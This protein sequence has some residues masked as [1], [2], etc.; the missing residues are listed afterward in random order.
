[1]GYFL[2]FLDELFLYIYAIFLEVNVD[3]FHFVAYRSSTC[4]RLIRDDTGKF[5]KGFYC[6]MGESIAVGAVFWGL[7][8]GIRLARKLSHSQGLFLSLIL[9]W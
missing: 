5:V 9:K 3:G 4:G 2:V 1:M 7:L 6:N 8:L